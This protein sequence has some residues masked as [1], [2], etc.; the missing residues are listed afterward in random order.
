MDGIPDCVSIPG[1][2]EDQADALRARYLAWIYELGETRINGERLVD[3]LELR[4]GFSAW[5][6]SLL[7]EKCNFAKSPQIDDAIRLIAFENWATGRSVD[8]VVL[9]SPSVRLAECVRSWCENAGVMFEWRRM[10]VKAN[11]LSW[12]KRLYQELPYPLQALVWL[13]HYLM[14][15]WPLRGV[16]LREWHEAKGRT[17]FI[18]YLFNLVP[19]AAKDGRFES[20]YWAHLPSDL[21]HEG[22]K[23]NWLHLYVKDGLLPTAGMAVDAIRQFNETSQGGQTHVTLD[24]FLG[25]GVVF[26]TLRDWFRLT[27]AGWYLQSGR[28]MPRVGDIDLWP[29]FRE[30][31]RR[32]L[33]GQVAISNAFFHNLFESA[34][35][36]LPEQRLGVYLQ[37]NQGWEF[38]LVHAWKAAGHGLLIGSPHSTVRYWD[39]RYFFDP[40]SYCRTGEN[41]LPLPDQVALNGMAA[42]DA[43]QKG[44]YPGVDLVEVE[45]LRYLHLAEARADEGSAL[46]IPSKSPLRILVLGDYLLSNTFQQMCLLETAV[47]YLPEGVIITVKSHPNCLVQPADYPGIRM[48]VTMEPVSKLLAE[49]DVAYTSSVTSAA[50]DAYCAGVPV[51]SV[52]DQN[53]LNLSPL[54]GRGGGIFASAP[55]E[56]ANALIF[57][58]STPR[59]VAGQKDFFTLDFK[60]PRWRKLLL[61]TPRISDG[62]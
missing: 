28:C 37:E 41:V 29:L 7:T 40:R 1:I 55:E 47:Q 60:L 43:Y 23:T 13:V 45:A 49:C 5:W 54:R 39:M 9:S 50:V 52:F 34:L 11:P 56:L 38:A 42:L 3:H 36:A 27:R 59:S 15:R 32:S 46:T 24:T 20:R 62:V 44:G 18:S 48:E 57:A 35:K 17:T 26:R 10:K 2:V 53:T 21:H 22:C 6:M 51:V 14:H 31:W 12:P 30:D 8:C 33:F 58:A 16:G 4:P 19:D 25:I 61:E